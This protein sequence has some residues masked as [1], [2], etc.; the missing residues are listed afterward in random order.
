MSRIEVGQSKKTIF[1]FVLLVSKAEYKMFKMFL[2]KQNKL[3][4]KMTKCLFQS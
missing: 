4:I 3:L 1:P 2:K